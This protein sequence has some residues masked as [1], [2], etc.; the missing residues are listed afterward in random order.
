MAAA[1]LNGLLSQADPR[2]YPTL[3]SILGSDKPKPKIE[4]DPAEA[5]NNARLWGMWLRSGARR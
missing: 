1:W 3:D 5:A 4:S 2:S